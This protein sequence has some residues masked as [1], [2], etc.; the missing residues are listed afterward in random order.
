[1]EDVSYDQQ[2]VALV[3]SMTES[4]IEQKDHLDIIL[5]RLLVLENMNKESPQLEARLQ[6]IIERTAKE[7]PQALLHE[8]EL[9]VAVRKQIIDSAEELDKLV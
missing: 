5:E 2:K 8:T 7:I 9:S 6:A 4:A 3:F 1:M